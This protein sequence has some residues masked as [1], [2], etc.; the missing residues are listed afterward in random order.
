M[1]LTNHENYY[2]DSRSHG[3]KDSAARLCR[4]IEKV[5]TGNRVKGTEVK[6]LDPWNRRILE[7]YFLHYTSKSTRILKIFKAGR[8]IN[9][10]TPVVFFISLR[11]DSICSWDSAIMVNHILK[12]PSLS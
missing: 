8:L 4:A 1:G 6:P 11:V 10:S 7:P 2:K 3:F 9:V 5:P 12:S